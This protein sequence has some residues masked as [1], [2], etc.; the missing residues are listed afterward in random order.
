MRGR[1][2]VWAPLPQRVRLTVGD[3]VVEMSRGADDWWTPDGPVPDGEVDYGYLLDDSE[4]RCC[5]TRGR[6]GSPTGYTSAPGPSTPRLRVDRRA[7]DRATAGRLGPLR[8]APRHLHARGHPRRR[9]RA[10]R[11]PRRAR[12]RPGRAAAGQRVQRHPQLGVRRRA[13]VGRARGVRRAGGVPALRRRRPRR[14]PR[15]DPGRRLQP[16]RPVGQLP[17]AVRS[18]P[19]GGGREHLGLAGQP[20]RRGLGG[21]TP[22][23]PRQRPIWLRDYH[24]DGLRL[25]AVHALFDESDVH[26]LEELAIEVAALSAHLTAAADPDRRVRPERRADG[27]AARGRRARASTRSGATTSTTR[28]TWR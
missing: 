13:L 12:R 19:Q 6:A 7:V 16:P 20:R 2:D 3:D 11:P 22:L 14:R 21:G 15:R 8:A 18:L 10:A 1:F 25:D 17:A 24:V 23:H 4:A 27:D 5:R 28:C 9:D 26:L